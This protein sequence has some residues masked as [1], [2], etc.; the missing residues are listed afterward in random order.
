MLND[1]F[2]KKLED[3]TNVSKDTIMNLA[4]KIQ[5]K[6]LKDET[7]LKEVIHELS[8]LTGKSLTEEQENKIINAVKGDNIPPDLEKFVE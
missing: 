7:T 8:S 4:S 5:N 6:D 1:N 3:K 2:F